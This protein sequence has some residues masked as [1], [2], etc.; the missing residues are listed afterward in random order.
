VALDPVTAGYR[1]AAAYARSLPRPIVDVSARVLSRAA[2]TVSA[3][4][5]MLVA[6]HLRRARPELAGSALDRA[7]DATFDSYARYWVDTFRLPQLTPAD[8]DFHFGVEGFHHIADPVAAGQGVILA[9]PHLGG[10]EWAGFWLTRV[11]GLKVSVVVETVEPRSLFDFFADIRR[12]LGM[13]IIPLGPSAGSEVLRS[14]KA[15]HVVCLLS[16]RDIL[17]DGV[18]L[19]FF[20]EATTLPAGPATLALR[21]GAPMVPVGCYFDGPH[22][23]RAVLQAPLPA[24]RQGRLRADVARLTGELAVRLEELIRAAPEQWHLQQPNWPSDYDALEAIGK[25]HPRPAVGPSARPA[26]AG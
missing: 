10:W 5:R 11:M 9:L 17:G 13:N 1:S 23:H 2:A 25:P 7:V 6:R 22:G 8:V 20:G 14:L 12:Q 4:R 15:G 16:D 18:E 21:T 3:E 26:E 24:E 19:E